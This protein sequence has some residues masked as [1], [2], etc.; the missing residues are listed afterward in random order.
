MVKKESAAID[1]TGNNYVAEWRF[2]T[3]YHSAA[4]ETLNRLKALLTKKV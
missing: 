1:N 3:E 4:Q 2:P